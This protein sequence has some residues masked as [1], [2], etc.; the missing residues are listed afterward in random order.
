M[1]TST[2]KKMAQWGLVPVDE[3]KPGLYRSSE[4]EVVKEVRSDTSELRKKYQEYLQKQG[5]ARK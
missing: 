1:P 2:S 3:K 4:K 5:G